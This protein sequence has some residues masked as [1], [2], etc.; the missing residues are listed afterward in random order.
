MAAGSW[1]GISAI[2]ERAH[3]VKFA[4]LGARTEASMPTLVPA[5]SARECPRCD[6]Q[7]VARLRVQ[8][9]L[10]RT[11]TK[12]LGLRVYRCM[13]CSHRFIGMSLGR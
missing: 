1:G 3:G 12:L 13:D 11:V 9:A 4:Y 8:G 6:S 2:S 5:T 10:G 7:A